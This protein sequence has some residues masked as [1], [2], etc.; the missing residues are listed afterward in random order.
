MAGPS[1]KYVLVTPNSDKTTSTEIQ[2]FPTMSKMSTVIK[3]L[4]EKNIAC[5]FAKIYKNC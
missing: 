5:S 1:D 2:Y 4:A 3:E